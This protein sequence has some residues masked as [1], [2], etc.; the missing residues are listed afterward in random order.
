MLKLKFFFAL[1]LKR[2]ILIILIS[3]SPLPAMLPFKSKT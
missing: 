1:L 2:K 3:F